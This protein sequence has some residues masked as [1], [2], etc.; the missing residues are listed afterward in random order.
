MNQAKQWI[1]RRAAPLCA[2]VVLCLFAP[3][4]G[5]VSFDSGSSAADQ[6]RAPAPGDPAPANTLVIYA[7]VL[8]LGAAALG[9]SVLPSRRGHQ[10]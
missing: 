3:A 6:V 2:A 10:D 8:A 1:G 7:V 4:M 5:Q 9:L